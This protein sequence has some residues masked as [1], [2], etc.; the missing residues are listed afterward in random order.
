MHK[1]LPSRDD[2]DG[3]NAS[4]REGGRELASIEDSVDASIQRL[5]DFIGKRGRRLITATR[6]N[7]NDVRT[8]SATITRK[9][10]FVVPVDHRVKLKESIKKK[11]KYLE[12]ARELKKNKQNEGHEDDGYTNINCCFWYSHQGIITEI[13]DAVGDRPNYSIVE[14]GQNTEKSPGNLRRLAVS[15]TPVK[16]SQLV[17]KT[18]KGVTTTIIMICSD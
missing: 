18:L 8:S 15:H 2:V 14:I 4:R 17:G 5:E 16:D 1:A 12:L 3:L 13:T 9:Q 10:N 11:G 7:T 6:N